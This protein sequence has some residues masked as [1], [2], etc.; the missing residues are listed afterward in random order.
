MSEPAEDLRMT[1]AEFLK[2]DDGTGTRYELIHGRVVAMAPPFEPHGRIA[3]NAGIQIDQRLRDRPACS[4]L[5]EGGIWLSDDHFYVA[6][7]V[8]TCAP[9]SRDGY[10]ADPFLI[11]EVIS[12][13][14]EKEELATKAQAY[15]QLPSVQEI[16]F[17]DSRKRWV[18]QWSR[19]GE[20]SWV[21]T[22][23]LTGAATFESPTLGGEPV[24]LD[25][26]YRNT[27]L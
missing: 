4:A 12:A 8:A 5:V 11:V 3:L 2:W 13:S 10:V 27:G 24:M 18:Q 1:A 16:W 23:P 26:L 14:N 9:P 21:V 25:Q 6:D 20:T 17:I 19:S 7:V 15:I 22:L